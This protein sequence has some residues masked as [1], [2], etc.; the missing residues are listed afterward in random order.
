MC[1]LLILVME[2]FFNGFGGENIDISSKVTGN[3]IAYIMFT[4]GST[5]NPKGVAISHSN[6]LSFAMEYKKI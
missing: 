3:T 5:G 1:M 6:I 2:V 4:S